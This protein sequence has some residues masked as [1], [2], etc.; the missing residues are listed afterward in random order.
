[1]KRYF[2]YLLLG[3]FFLLYCAPPSVER[4]ALSLTPILQLLESQT[5]KKSSNVVVDQTI[6]PSPPNVV[7]DQTITPSPPPPLTIEKVANPVFSPSSSSPY[8][9]PVHIAITTS[10]AGATI[11][12]TL[13][14][15]TPTSSSTLYQAPLHIWRV[16]GNPIKAIAV[17]SGMED[18]DVVTQVYSYIPLKTGLDQSYHPNDDFAVNFGVSRSYYVDNA[19]GT[20]SDTA[21]GLVW[22]K[23]SRGQSLPNCSGTATTHDWNDSKNYCESLNLA[24]KTWRLPTAEELLTLR[25]YGKSTNPAI[26]TTFFPATIG[27][28]IPY[29]TSDE[30]LGTAYLLNFRADNSVSTVFYSQAKTISRHV[31]CVS[32]PSRFYL[33]NFVDNGN[34]TVKDL[35]TGL[36]WQKCSSGQNNDSTCSGSATSYSNNWTQA[37]NDCNSLNLASLTWRLPNINELFSLHLVRIFN[38]TLFS[39][40]FPNTPSSFFISST[41]LKSNSSKFFA[42]D[43]W[44]W[45]NS[46]TSFSNRSVRCVAG[47]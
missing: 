25:D 21:T 7:V 4:N 43:S 2:S 23:C 31:R 41:S 12:Y 17:K 11:Y 10:T 22:Q 20:I 18:S 14:G 38:P 1:M 19:D 47:P 36:I 13:D 34:G 39:N 8:F 37:L 28:G 29:W 32:G 44:I 33:G 16:A 35:A 27:S 42:A 24:S 9:V 15:T 46:K 26:D 30:S 40:T 6:T 5:P 45:A 3:L